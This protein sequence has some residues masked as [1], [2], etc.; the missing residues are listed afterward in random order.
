[1]QTAALPPDVRKGYAF[2]SFDFISARLRL[3]VAD[4]DVRAPKDLTAHF[5]DPIP[6]STTRATAGIISRSFAWS[7]VK[8]T[9]TN[10]A[11]FGSSM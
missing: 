1:M 9:R 11:P 8:V 7:V 6:S 3:A 10:F 2:P 5:N 4:G